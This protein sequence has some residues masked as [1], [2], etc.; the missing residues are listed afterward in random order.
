M[1]GHAEA[2]A[3]REG[4]ALDVGCGVGAIV[5]LTAPGLAGRE[6]ELS[7][8]G[9]RSPRVHTVVHERAAGSTLVHAAVFV[10]VAEGAYD[11][12]AP[13]GSAERVRVGSGQIA[14]VDWRT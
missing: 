11:L 2:A 3:A 10:D 6:V 13:S 5:V 8:A 12:W 14:T 4:V 9:A 1:T 7:R